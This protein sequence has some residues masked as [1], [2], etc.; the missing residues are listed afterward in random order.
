MAGAPH[1]TIVGSAAAH[2]VD[3]RRVVGFAS[4]GPERDCDAPSDIGQLYAINLDPNVW[5]RGIGRALLNVATD[6]L[7]E[8]GYVEAVLWVVPESARP[9]LYESEGWSDDDLR[10]DD[11]VFGV[12]VSQ[13]RYRR[14]LVEPSDQ[15]GTP[16]E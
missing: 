16:S 14:L 12:V 13:M 11:E 3:D 15:P 5:G 7:R 2:V 9:R 8:L 4:L 1:C 10:R 6:R